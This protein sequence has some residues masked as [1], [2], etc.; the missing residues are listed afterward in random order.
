MAKRYNKGVNTFLKILFVVIA[1]FA[2]MILVVPTINTADITNQSTL[3]FIQWFV[4]L[5]DDLAANVG[6][7]AFMLAGIGVGYYFL[8]YKPKAK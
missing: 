2:L 7:Y 1:I 5:K 8:A 4:D 3:D 6:L